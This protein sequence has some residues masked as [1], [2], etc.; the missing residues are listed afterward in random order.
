MSPHVSWEPLGK[1]ASLVRNSALVCARSLFDNLVYIENFI[2]GYAQ[3]FLVVEYD[4]S[5]IWTVGSYNCY[6]L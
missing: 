3:G 5:V 4:G 6:G 2:Q 1:E